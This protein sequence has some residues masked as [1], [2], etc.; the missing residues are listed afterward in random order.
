[1]MHLIID[2]RKIISIEAVEQ[3]SSAYF[4]VFKE[5]ED[6]R[7]FEDIMGNDAYHMS[8]H[9]TQVNKETARKRIKVVL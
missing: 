5:Y 9:I 8:Q 2:N 3:S 7:K 1:M 6:I 4:F